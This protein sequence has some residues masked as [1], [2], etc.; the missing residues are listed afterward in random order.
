[1]VLRGHEDK[2]RSISYN[3]VANRIASSSYDGTLRVWDAKSGEE[4]AKAEVGPSAVAYSPDGKYLAMTVKNSKVSIRDAQT[5][6]EI[7]SLDAG[8]SDAMH[9]AFNRQGTML[10]S[11]GARSVH[12]WEITTKKAAPDKKTPDAKKRP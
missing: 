4:I 9:L 12:V 3:P 8:N 11:A 2:I 10:A 6:E 5:L 7:L 1:M